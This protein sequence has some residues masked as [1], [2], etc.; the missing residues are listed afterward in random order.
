[1]LIL[2]VKIPILLNNM[3]IYDGVSLE[4]LAIKQNKQ[5]KIYLLVDILI[6]KINY[7]MIYN[8]PKPFSIH[9]SAPELW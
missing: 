5:I 6:P 1:M 7:R 3:P 2:L 4:E 8:F 9:L